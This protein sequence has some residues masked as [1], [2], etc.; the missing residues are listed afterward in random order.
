MDYNFFRSRAFRLFVITLVAGFVMSIVPHL[1]LGAANLATPLAKMDVLESVKVKLE[2]KIND[3]SLV[4]PIIPSVSAGEEYEQASAFGVIDFDSGEII[5]S[6]NLSEKLPMA[7][8]TK[9]MTAVV[10]L[11]LASP[12]EIFEVSERAASQVPSKV[13]LRSGERVSFSDLLESMLISSANDSAQTI[14]EGIDKKYGGPVFIGAMNLKAEILGL[15]NT[16]FTNPA[17]FDSP[18][19]FSSIE[20][21][22]TLSHYAMTNYP[23]IAQIVSKEFE[24]LTNGEDPRFFLNNW[25]GLLG[26]YPGTKGIKIGN[27]G[28]AGKTTIVLSE[29]EGKKIL[30]VLLGAPGV[31][32]RDLWASELLNLGFEKLGIDPVEV[33]EE[34]LKDKYASWRYAE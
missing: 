29:R 14:L 12:D 10:G 34:Q 6:K 7:S 23:K 24:D 27:T 11:D 9:V 30:I 13:M 32:E 22:A 4:K 20:D 16:H 15:K 33:T 5:A 1:N 18:N 21:L 26:I 8:L 28:K 2:E 19:H 3:F 25:N 31:L 17:G